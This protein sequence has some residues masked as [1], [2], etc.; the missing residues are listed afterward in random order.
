ML[1]QQ[2]IARVRVQ[3]VASTAIIK[4]KTD[5]YLPAPLGDYGIVTTV[6]RVGFCHPIYPSDPPV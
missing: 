4:R 1:E 3:N 2:A 5:G 6:R